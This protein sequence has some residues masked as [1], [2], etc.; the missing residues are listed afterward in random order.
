MCISG[1][2]S[3]KEFL[4]APVPMLLPVHLLTKSHHNLQKRHNFIFH[5]RAL[6][7]KKNSTVEFFFPA[8]K[9]VRRPVYLLQK[10]A[11]NPQKSQNRIFRSRALLFE[12]HKWGISRRVCPNV[13]AVHLPPKP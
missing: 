3:N 7:K 4:D 9:V 8:K 5:R 11:N 13:L 2:N 10:N 1:F 12:T 6:L